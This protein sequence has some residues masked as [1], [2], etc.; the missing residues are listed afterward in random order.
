M[1]PA[2][3]AIALVVVARGSSSGRRRGRRCRAPPPP[4]P[5][6]RRGHRA[7]AHAGSFDGFGSCRY[8]R[9]V[10]MRD[11]RAGEGDHRRDLERVVEAGER[12]RRRLADRVGGRAAP[13]ATIA[14]MIAIP[15]EPP[16]WRK[17]FS[18]AEPTP[19]LST[20]TE[21][22]AAAVVG[23]IVSAMP[24]P[25][26][27]QPGEDVPE[28]RVHGPGARRS[29]A[30]RATSS[31]PVADQPAR[32]DPVGELARDGRDEDDQHRHRQE[33]RAG[34]RSGSSRGRSGCR[35][36]CR[37]RRRTSR[38]RRAASRCSRR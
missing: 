37:R 31:R 23:V 36:R 34:L 24:K 15:S 6:R 21:P 12:T 22:I 13:A 35:A 27:D 16:T 29:G 26:S 20:G 1:T 8:W 32:A 19:A 7:D 38:A 28:G 9:M 18:T 17:L 2:S 10:A 11:H 30:S 4:L 5:P 25:P 14:P 3:R 33:D